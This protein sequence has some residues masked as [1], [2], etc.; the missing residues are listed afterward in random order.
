MCLTCFA[1]LMR[2]LLLAM[3]SRGKSSLITMLLPRRDLDFCSTA[4]RSCNTTSV[5]MHH[6]LRC[7]TYGLFLEGHDNGLH[8][9][10]IFFLAPDNLDEGHVPRYGEL[11]ADHLKWRT[12]DKM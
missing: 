4:A 2:C 1:N 3:M 11:R 6:H 9:L 8:P 5:M 12:I 10:G 7:V